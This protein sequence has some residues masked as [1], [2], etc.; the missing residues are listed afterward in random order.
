M[1]AGWIIDRKSVQQLTQQLDKE[2]AELTQ[3]RDELYEKRKA[4]VSGCFV[5]WMF[6]A[7]IFVCFLFHNIIS[8]KYFL[9]W[10]WWRNHF[11]FW[12]FFVF[13]FEEILRDSRTLGF[14][15]LVELRQL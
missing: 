12:L 6:N 9:C 4:V 3:T 7:I 11:L 14:L 5:F 8:A 13:F 1:Q 10:L 15:S 2:S